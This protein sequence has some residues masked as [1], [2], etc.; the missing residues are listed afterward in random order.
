MRLTPTSFPL[1]ASTSCRWSRA[2][3]TYADLGEE[4]LRQLIRAALNTHYLGAASAE[5]FNFGGKTDIYINHEGQSLFIAE[6]KFWSGAQGFVETL[7]Q[8]FG[9]QAWRDTK[10][11]VIVFVRNQGFSEVVE[12]G[13]EALG[14]HPLFLNW[15]DSASGTELRAVV[16]SARDERRHA[17]LNVFFIPIATG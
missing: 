3:G 8:L 16:R 4:D 5:A 9:Y 10:L 15:G 17:D 1:S 11:A 13:R 14:N 6:C 2:P 7:N 12:K